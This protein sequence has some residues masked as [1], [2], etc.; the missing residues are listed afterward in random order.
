[1]DKQYIQQIVDQIDNEIPRIIVNTP[2]FVFSA[3]VAQCD[4]M[5]SNDTWPMH[6]A[7]AMGTKTIGLFGP[8]LPERFAPY[9]AEKN[10]SLYQGDGTAYIN[11][12]LGQFLPCSREIIDSITPEMVYTHAKEILGTDKPL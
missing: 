9:P 2:L 8:N 11:V 1:M 6:I 5:I 3:L 4:L 12:H 7:A 10:I